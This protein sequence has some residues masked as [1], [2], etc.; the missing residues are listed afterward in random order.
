MTKCSL[1]LVVPFRVGMGGKLRSIYCEQNT[2]R[3]N[4]HLFWR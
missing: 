3:L 2:E 1:R 4:C